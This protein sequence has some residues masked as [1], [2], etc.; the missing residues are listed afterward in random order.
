M[1]PIR[2]AAVITTLASALAGCGGHSRSN[3]VGGQAPPTARTLLM[4]DGGTDPDEL[5][6]F[7]ERVRE[8]SNGSLR[9]KLHD[10]WR[11]GQT[12]WETGLIRDVRADRADLGW[13][14]PRA[15]DTVGVESFR[16]LNAPLLIDTY[17]LEE[18]VLA[19]PIV[20][21]ML[22]ALKPHGLVGLGILPGQMR[23]PFGVRHPLLRPADFA[24]KVLGAQESGVADETLRALGART[25]RLPI[26]RVDVTR[27]DGLEQR[28]STIDAWY[29]RHGGYLSANVNLWPR[30][31]VLFANAK[32]FASLTAAQ[33]RALHQAATGLIRAQTAHVVALDR[34]SGGNICRAA[35]VTLQTATARDL[36]RLRRAVQPV[37]RDLEQDP[38]THRAI[39]AIA[40]LKHT[41]PPA[42]PDG[43]AGCT[44]PAAA[45]GQRTPVDG[46]WTMTTA[47]RD[48]GPDYLAENWGKWVY[49][50]DRGRF[51]DTQENRPSCTWGYGTYVVRGNTFA[52]TF[53]N[54][55]GEA[56]NGAF[57]KPG[58]FFVFG[59]SRYRDTLTLTPVKG[60][61]SPSNFRVRTW[62]LVSSTPSRSHLSKRCSPPAGALAR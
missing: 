57:N 12:T 61:T 19:S 37:Y 41:A 8:L 39:T 6:P 4:A 1:T 20:R 31:L 46:T 35:S 13:A 45:G 2:W 17:A 16:A 3:R 50:F 38:A 33:Q 36:A 44:R 29:S 26:T 47:R 58:E 34:E 40:Q 25:V 18:K 49:V 30:P 56:P 14:A 60:E 32:V 9:I 54:G 48:A 24:G 28:V 21:P 15:W 10:S 27:Y 7:V 43:L 52:W 53:K 51:A 23:R 11:A 59:W 42:A 62:R 22:A 55:G 5:E